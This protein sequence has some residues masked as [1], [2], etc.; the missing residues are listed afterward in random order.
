MVSTSLPN[1]GMVSTSSTSAADGEASRVGDANPA[2][3]PPPPAV[4]EARGYH[5][6]QGLSYMATSS[7]TATC[8]KR[9]YGEGAPRGTATR[10]LWVCSPFFTWYHHF[11]IWQATRV[12]WVCCPF[13]FPRRHLPS[14]YLYA[15]RVVVRDLMLVPVRLRLCHIIIHVF[16]TQSLY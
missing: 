8:S 16:I 7:C 4:K 14:Q 13:R 15:A 10:V 1:K 12:L 6:W 5:I 2:A 3:P 11:L 9:S